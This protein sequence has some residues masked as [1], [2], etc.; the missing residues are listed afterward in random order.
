MI[1]CASGG[2]PAVRDSGVDRQR[3]E[4]DSASDAD[5]IRA[6]FPSGYEVLSNTGTRTPSGLSGYDLLHAEVDL[7][8]DFDN[9]A[10]VGTVKYHLVVLRRGLAEILLH[11][12]G[13][14][15][16]SAALQR[17][18]SVVLS[19]FR[20]VNDGIVVVPR[21]A[22]RRADTLSL[23]IQYRANGAVDAAHGG[24]HFVDP[25]GDDPSL[26]T[27]V[28][29]D[30]RPA[31]VRAWLPGWNHPAETM[32]FELRLNVPDS[33]S[34]F[35]S[36]QLI[37]EQA[38]DNH[39]R[40]DHWAVDIPQ[41]A[42]RI[43]FAVGTFTSVEDQ[44][45]S[46]VGK[47][48]MLVYG[49]DPSAGTLIDEVFYPTPDMV[50]VM[51]KR[52]AVEY[53]FSDYKQVAVRGYP[54]VV[55]G[56]AGLTILGSAVMR[57]GRALLDDRG[58]TTLMSGLASQWFGSW[59]SAADWSDMAILGGLNR[60]LEWAYLEE[61][62]GVDAAREQTIRARERYFGEAENVRRPAIWRSSRS[63]GHL[64][65]AHSSDKAALVLSQLAFVIGDETFWRAG[66]EL[67]ARHAKRAVSLDDVRESM[68]QAARRLLD[69]YFNQWFLQPGHPEIIIEHDYDASGGIYAIRIRQVQDSSLFPTYVI[70]TDIELNF[71]SR[72]AYSERIRI[73]SRD[74][75]LTFGVSGRI[76]FVTVDADHRLL[77][78]IRDRKPL[79]Q[80]I[81][82]AELDDAVA[83]RYGAVKV[84]T[85]AQRGD[86][87][88]DALIRVAGTDSS[89]LVRSAALR[90]LVGYAGSAAVLRFA[91]AQTVSDPAPECRRSALRLLQGSADP[92]AVRV[93]REALRDSSYGVVATAVEVLGDLSPKLF[94][95]TVEPIS[96]GHSW[97]GV[98][99]RSIAGVLETNPTASSAA[100]LRELMEP[101]RA[102]AVRVAALEAYRNLASLGPDW[103]ADVKSMVQVLL[104]DRN[105]SVRKQAREIIQEL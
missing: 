25:A 50:G 85:R 83:A 81:A 82:Q 48:S 64:A 15:V 29:T 13:I 43:G 61:V 1:G 20:V 7:S 75:T 77:A 44:Y 27:Q 12:Q 38:S 86:E 22:L 42:D 80:W 26:P 93:V 53:P 30:V 14:R 18:G 69:E 49:A 70:D 66:R 17:D 92:A 4:P 94:W 21:A 90:G 73:S 32:T 3:D 33:L 78:D 41:P 35:A 19:E 100:Y 9:A 10:V 51:E 88:R 23:S 2:S 65:A 11:G 91:L 47:R 104:S 16:E 60:M 37:D 6:G 87:V 102:E 99:E 59:I 98:V 56:T 45:V 8:F 68:E 55:G 95:T 5:R 46:P 31:A 28:W 74:T 84:L 58:E 97:E 71:D 72:P 105:L 76:A 52:T 96:R 67:L 101:Q 36:G 34:T 40:V 57:D 62:H 79:W 89:P 39:H 54:D 63:D 24:V 103:K